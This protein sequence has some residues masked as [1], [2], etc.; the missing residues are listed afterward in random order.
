M[1]RSILSK[2]NRSQEANRLLALESKCQDLRLELDETARKLAA[3]QRQ[4]VLLHERDEEQLS[5]QQEAYKIQL[6]SDLGG[7]AVQF[8]T[9]LNLS[10]AQQQ[11]VESRDA[12]AVAKS[13]LRFSKNQGLE[14]F[15]QIGEAYNFDPEYHEPIS[16]DDHLSAGM[17]VIVRIPGVS[18]RD[19]VLR[20]AGVRLDGAG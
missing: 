2:F 15:G 14:F 1:W 13:L 8:M 6:F 10:E 18:Y 5:R 3:A 12:L 7:I 11:P 19:Q 17:K 20:K 9:L 16:T 4:L